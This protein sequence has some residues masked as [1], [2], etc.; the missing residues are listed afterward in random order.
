MC[1]NL[2]KKMVLITRKQGPLTTRLQKCGE[3]CL[4]GLNQMCGQS[5]ASSMKCAAS[6]SLFRPK[7]CTNYLASFAKGST[8]PY[9]KNTQSSCAR[10]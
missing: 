4:T 3:I 6:N 8:S 1:P 5:G 2:Q 10:W 7:I 9:L